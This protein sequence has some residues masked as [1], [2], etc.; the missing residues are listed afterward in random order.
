MNP[1]II[2]KRAIT[3]TAGFSFFC[4][5]TK[6]TASQAFW[7]IDF[8]EAS[9]DPNWGLTSAGEGGSADPEIG[10][11]KMTFAPGNGSNFGRSFIVTNK[12]NDGSRLFENNPNFNFF[13]HNIVI[14]V[15]GLS[16]ESSEALA[17]GVTN[18]FFVM[19][20]NRTFN[21]FSKAFPRD[22]DTSGVYF[23]IAQG[24]SFIRL[25]IC[26]KLLS[27][28]STKSFN[29]DKIPSQ[30]SIALT[31]EGW[32]VELID[33]AFVEGDIS[34][35]SGLWNTITSSDFDG[36]YAFSLGAVNFDKP[37]SEYTVSVSKFEIFPNILTTTSDVSNNDEKSLKLLSLNQALNGFFY[38]MKKVAY[39]NAANKIQFFE[40]KSAKL[41]LNPA[42]SL[43]Q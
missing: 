6:L 40:P 18:N 1:S 9:L 15:S 17:D 12:S 5:Q 3:L 10:N 14:R 25:I 35:Q 13:S 39:Q 16:I 21:T 41:S 8:S 30:I 28:I 7:N 22:L 26:E 32:D 24:N 34:S 37:V 27:S 11:Q 2:I 42:L 20:S 4:C 33:A 43:L 31:S 19:I 38:S 29:I 23:R 36:N